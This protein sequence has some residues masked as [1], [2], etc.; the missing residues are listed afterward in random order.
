MKIVINSD[1]SYT[2]AIND[3]YDLYQEQKYLKVSVTV[4]KDRSLEQNAISHTWYS[5]VSDKLKEHTPGE[6][7]SLCKLHRGLPILRGEDEHFNEVCCKVIDPLPYEDK[8][9]AMEIL[10]VTSL[11]TIKQM[12]KYLEAV[13]AN[14][15][16]RVNLT[17]PEET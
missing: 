13:Q 11:M 17:F 16:G 3:L 8:L 15:L 10:P 12:S 6:V 7:K 2:R 1:S 9:K 4:G 5:E 14:Y